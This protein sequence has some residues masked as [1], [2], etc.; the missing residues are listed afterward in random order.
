VLA[1]ATR[2]IQIDKSGFERDVWLASRRYRFAYGLA[3]VLLS[4]GLGWAAALA[5]RRRI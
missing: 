3:C 4:L 2:D 1:V 5:F